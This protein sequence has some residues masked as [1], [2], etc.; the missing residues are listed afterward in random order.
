[1]NNENYF[2][3]LKQTRICQ[4]HQPVFLPHPLLCRNISSVLFA[5]VASSGLKS[6]V[7]VCLP[8]T[9]LCEIWKWIKVE[10]NQMFLTVFFLDKMSKLLW[11]SQ[12]ESI[13]CKDNSFKRSNFSS[14]A[15]FET[16]CVLFLFTFFLDIFVH[17]KQFQLPAGRKSIDIKVNYFGTVIVLPG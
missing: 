12:M 14:Y 10:K 15:F 2:C 6:L 8:L 13:V 3:P 16:Q 1:M 9:L 4:I 7:T 5:V 11:T 17:G